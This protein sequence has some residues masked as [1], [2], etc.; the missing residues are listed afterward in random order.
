M[1]VKIECTYQYREISNKA[2]FHGLKCL[3]VCI[4]WTI[5][6]LEGPSNAYYLCQIRVSTKRDGKGTRGLQ[7]YHVNCFI[8]MSP[9][10]DIKKVFGWDNLE[11]EEKENILRLFKMN[12]TDKEEGT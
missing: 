4:L 11:P 3:L 2:M 7:W 1:R 8:E 5:G 12:N 9:S 10:T 6:A